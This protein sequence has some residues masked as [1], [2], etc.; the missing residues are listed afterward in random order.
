M[1]RIVAV[2]LAVAMLWYGMAIGE[3]KQDELLESLDKLCTAYAAAPETFGV[4]ELIGLY[5]TYKVFNTNKIVDLYSSFQALGDLVPDNFLKTE[6]TLLEGQ[7]FESNMMDNLWEKWLKDELNDEEC[8]SQMMVVI[9]IIVK[10]S[11]RATGN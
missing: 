2:M 5:A 10:N 9:R 7:L 4:Q 6:K 3:E 8:L 11:K 1:K